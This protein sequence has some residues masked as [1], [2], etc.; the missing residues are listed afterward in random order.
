VPARVGRVSG[1]ALPLEELKLRPGGG[2]SPPGS[3]Q[4]RQLPVNRERWGAAGCGRRE[5]RHA[6]SAQETPGAPPPPLRSNFDQT[7]RSTFDV[8]Q[9]S[10]ISQESATHSREMRAVVAA[11]AL[12]AVLLP[13]A[14]AFASAPSPAL[15]AVSGHR[16][17]SMSAADGSE[18][19]PLSRRA[20]LF[21][22]GAAVAAGAAPLPAFAQFPGFDAKGD[23][24]SGLGPQGDGRYLSLCDSANCVSSSEDVYSKRFLPP[25]TYNDEGKKAKTREQAMGDLLEVLKTTKGATVVTQKPNYVYAEFERELGLVDDVEFL[26]SP[27]GQ[28]VEYRSAARK[29]KQSDHR[30][31]IKA[32][33]V[34]LQKKGWRS[35]GFR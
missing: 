27:D 35:L 2:L 5:L 22:A 30:G 19:A 8:L 6:V 3:G 25:W 9:G 28:T 17:V 29:A 32:L 20:A 23:R 10:P 12:A 13:A 1:L 34:E 16:C 33:R 11:G 7:L 31:R 24:P 18:G 26:F 14:D 21:A 4:R 15:R